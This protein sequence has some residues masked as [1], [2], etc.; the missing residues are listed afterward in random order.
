[1]PVTEIPD[2]AYRA[3]AMWGH[4]YVLSY[5]IGGAADNVPHRQRAVALKALGVGSHECCLIRTWPRVHLFHPR[6]RYPARTWYSRPR[7]TSLGLPQGGVPPPLLWLVY[8]YSGQSD[9][10]HARSL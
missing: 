1:M 6:L 8:F 10:T 3:L 4:M 7:S 2:F 5:D 9:F